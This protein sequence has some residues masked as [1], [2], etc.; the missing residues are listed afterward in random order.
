ME[1]GNLEGEREGGRGGRDRDQSHSP[2]K[3]Q[4]HTLLERPPLQDVCWYDVCGIG[5]TVLAEIL[6]HVVAEPEKLRV[7]GVDLHAT[8]S[9]PVTLSSQLRL[10]VPGGRG[11][12][13]GGGGAKSES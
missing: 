4:S 13:K 7:G 6:A 5:V 3:I 8:P 10:H 11:M 2:H 1:T 9:A 12:G